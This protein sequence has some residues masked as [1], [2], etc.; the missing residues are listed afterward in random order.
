M[1]SD[2]KVTLCCRITTSK[3]PEIVVTVNK[4]WSYRQSIPGV[5]HTEKHA[6]VN[7]LSQHKR[8]WSQESGNG[9]EE[10]ALC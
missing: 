4:G 3:C 7:S 2:E 5:Q 1:Q 9:T 8:I 6:L 10:M